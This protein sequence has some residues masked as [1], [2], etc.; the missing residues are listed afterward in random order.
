MYT[1]FTRGKLRES[2]NVRQ[3]DSQECGDGTEYETTYESESDL[4][5][6]QLD[7]KLIHVE[8][9]DEDVV[10]FSTVGSTGE[11]KHAGIL[12]TSEKRGDMGL[13]INECDDV[14]PL[15]YNVPTT[16]TTVTPVVRPQPNVV[17]CRVSRADPMC[18]E[19]RDQARR[20]D[21]DCADLKQVRN[22]RVTGCS[23][24][25]ASCLSDAETTFPNTTVVHRSNLF[26]P[27][28]QAASQQY[29]ANTPTSSLQSPNTRG[30]TTN[31]H[32]DNQCFATAVN[33]ENVGNQTIRNANIVSLNGR[34]VGISETLAS[35]S[36]NTNEL[37]EDPIIRAT[38]MQTLMREENMRYQELENVRNVETQALRNLENDARRPASPQR[39]V[40]ENVRNVETQTQRNLEPEDRRPAAPQRAAAARAA[41]VQQPP[42]QQRRITPS[43]VPSARYQQGYTT[44]DTGTDTDDSSN[45]GE[46]DREYYEAGYHE[47]PQSD[48]RLRQHRHNRRAMENQQY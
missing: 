2:T 34:K 3:V 45:L 23:D 46:S 20:V 44:T 38:L 12:T 24:M 30:E 5:D 26:K 1:M 21:G 19:R 28:C 31:S 41:A 29:P 6:R 37:L 40:L 43:A 14:D 17:K 11:N 7:R 18:H 39:S 13:T 32:L 10:A 16:T 9:E 22:V 33:G 48:A 42:V 4:N 35:L 15:L 8:N 36:I 27:Q 25:G 47:V